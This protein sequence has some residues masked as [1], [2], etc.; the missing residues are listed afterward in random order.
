LLVLGD[1]DLVL[2]LV[3]EHAQGAVEAFLE[4]IGHGDQAGAAAGAEGLVGGAGAAAAA[5]DQR[6]LDGVTGGRAEGEAFRGEV[7]EGDAAEGGG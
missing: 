2:V 4:G 7:G 6:D 3:L 5:A 1:L